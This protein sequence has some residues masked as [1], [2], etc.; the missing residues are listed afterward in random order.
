MKKDGVQFIPRAF[1]SSEGYIPSWCLSWE[2]LESKQ[3]PELNF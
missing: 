3:N 2:D 1:G